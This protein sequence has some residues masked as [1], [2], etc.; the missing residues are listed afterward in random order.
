MFSF[1]PRRAGRVN[2]IVGVM[3]LLIS[4]FGLLGV[5]ASGVSG[6]DLASPAVVLFLFVF[7]GGYEVGKYMENRTAKQNIVG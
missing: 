7:M 6:S 1:S 3:L 4:V 5:S 2:L